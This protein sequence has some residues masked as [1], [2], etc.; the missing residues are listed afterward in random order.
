[1]PSA[2]AKALQG[3]ALES[4]RALPIEKAADVI[5]ALELGVKQERLIQGEPSERSEMSVEEVTKREMRRWL[6]IGGGDGEAA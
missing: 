3:K 5:R 4:L 6:V 1:M 2:K